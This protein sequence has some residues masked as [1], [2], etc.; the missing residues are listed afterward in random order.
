[1]E[2]MGT[3]CRHRRSAPG[4]PQKAK[5][6]DQYAARH[7]P[8]VYFHSIIDTPRL[9][10][11]RASRSAR[12]ARP[13]SGATTPNLVYITPEPL[14]RRP[15]RALRRRAARR[16]VS[17]ST[18][19]C[20]PGCPDPRLA[21]LPAG[22]HAGDHR[23]RV[24]Q[25]ADRR[26]GLL[27]R[28][29]SVQHTAAGDRGPGGGKVGALVLVRWTRPVR[30]AAR[31]TTTTACWP[32]WRTSS[33]LRPPRLRG[34]GAK[35]HRFG[36]DVYTRAGGA[37]RVSGRRAAGACRRRSGGAGCT[38]D[39]TGRAPAAA[40]SSRS[41][42]AA[43]PSPAAGRAPPTRRLRSAR[44]SSPTFL[45][46][47]GAQPGDLLPQAAAATSWWPAPPPVA[48]DSSC[49]PARCRWRFAAS[50]VRHRPSWCAC[51]CR[52]ARLGRCGRAAARVPRRRGPVVA[53]VHHPRAEARAGLLGAADQGQRRQ[54]HREH[55]GPTA[56]R[57]GHGGQPA[58]R[59]GPGQ[60]RRSPRRR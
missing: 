14:L 25:P 23:R 5:V 3:P 56:A 40:W 52:P 39:R 20:G 59:P 55:D 53:P 44:S 2:D 54:Q 29:A 49:R 38:P 32:R 42:S 50:S 51:P 17:A 36:R 58:R 9:R 13:A 26:D 27:R 18:R 8:F 45:R 12:C 30:G 34:G 28:G 46:A 10:G 43:M 48:R 19:G 47:L 1:M 15:R 22:R 60:W 11:A 41:R 35:L 33:A 31:R 24:R 37:E 7:D 4:R 16:P 21:G 57:R 6:G